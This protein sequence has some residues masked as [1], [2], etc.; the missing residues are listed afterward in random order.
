MIRVRLVAEISGRVG[1]S[2]G[3]DVPRGT[4]GADVIERRKFSREQERVFVG[5]R[6]RRDEADAFRHRGERGEERDWLERAAIR[7]LSFRAGEEVG[8]EAIGQEDSV[9]LG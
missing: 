3:Y 4:A 2:G 7:G 1:D 6:S 5:G 8:S 9:Q